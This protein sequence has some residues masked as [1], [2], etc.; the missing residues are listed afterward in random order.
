MILPK[1]G[2]PAVLCRRLLAGHKHALK[3]S[4][5]PVHLA[6]PYLGLVHGNERMAELKEHVKHA[7][8]S[9][10]L[11]ELRRIDAVGLPHH[12]DVVTVAYRRLELMQEVEDSR[13]VCRR[14]MHRAQTIRAIDVAILKYGGFL[15]IGN[16]VDAESAHALA[17]PE[18]R[19]V[20]EGLAHL[21]ILPVEVGLLLGERMQVELLP[22]L[23]PLPRTAAKDRSPIRGRR[24]V[25]PR[26]APYVPV[27]LVVL[28]R[29]ARLHEP[30][31]FL[32][33][34]IE[35]Q[36]HHHAYTP[37]APTRYELVHVGHGAK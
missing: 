7:P 13:G 1:R 21:G 11:V 17:Y 20:K 2:I 31:A 27:S 16:G 30:R 3:V 25:G 35:Y 8:L 9:H 12:K 34:V 10:P 24:P 6:T 18:V 37:L 19:D 26:V 29:R 4:E 28:A 36:V 15:Y 5:R 14:G 23:A 22:L 33:R 32:R